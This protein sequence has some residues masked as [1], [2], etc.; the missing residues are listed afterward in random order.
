M[1]ASEDMVV[2]HD[3]GR[4]RIWQWLTHLCI[5]CFYSWEEIVKRVILPWELHIYFEARG[6]ANGD[7]LL[8]GFDCLLYGHSLL[9][10]GTILSWLLYF[11]QRLRSW[12]PGAWRN[13]LLNLAAERP[14]DSL[15]DALISAGW[16]TR[17]A[18]DNRKRK[19]IFMKHYQRAQTVETT[20]LQDAEFGP[21]IAVAAVAQLL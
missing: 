9:C 6:P 19:F 10:T 17:E 12:Q 3:T 15:A 14:D 20:Y 18:Y 7:D 8:W 13:R 11:N 1:A 2:P 21:D 16:I 5:P 4:G